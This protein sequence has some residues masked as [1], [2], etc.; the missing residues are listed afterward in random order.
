MIKVKIG[1]VIGT[2]GRS[3]QVSKIEELPS[4]LHCYTGKSCMRNGMPRK[5][6]L[7]QVIFEDQILRVNYKKVKYGKE[8]EK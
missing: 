2:T 3:I 5:Y 7:T 6:P 4:G 8:Y 1:D